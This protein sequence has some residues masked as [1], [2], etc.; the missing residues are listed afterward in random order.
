MEYEI[1]ELELPGG[2]VVLARVSMASEEEFTAAGED[3]GAFTDV[4]ARDRLAAWSRQLDRLITG[5]GRAVHEAARR[6]AP[7]EV[8]ATFGVELVAKPGRAVAA[9]IADAETRASIS[10]TL[11]W[12]PGETRGAPPEDRTAARD[13]SP[14]RAP[15]VSP[16]VPPIP[17]QPPQAAP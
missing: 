15:A 10:V 6:T 9:V 11:T 16:P 12:R 3:G 17:A 13:T 8:S 2:E 4:G 14:D 5:V 7:H 1:R